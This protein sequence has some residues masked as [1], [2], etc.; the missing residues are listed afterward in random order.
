MKTLAL[1]L[2]LLASCKPSAVE[3]PQTVEPIATSS[4]TPNGGGVTT[5][6]IITLKC[7]DTCTTQERNE[8]PAIE[9][10]MN[11]TLN[12]QC[13]TDYFKSSGKRFDNANGVSV[14]KM[15]EKLRTPTALTLNYYSQFGKALGYES[16]DDFSVIHFNR[17]NLGGW[18]ICDKASLGAHEFSHTKGFFH[19]GNRASP[20]YY[21]I[22]YQLNHAFDPKSY[23][24]YNGG[25][26]K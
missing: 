2:L 14:D 5:G 10:A 22:P 16:A 8:L 11:D 19:I 25:C 24:S 3:V 4:P 12:S 7:D 9:K 6:K 23:D 13:F 20:N 1:F 21:S 18:T 26:C 15:L 17:R